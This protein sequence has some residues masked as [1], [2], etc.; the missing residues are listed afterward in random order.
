MCLAL[1]TVLTALAFHTFDPERF[2]IDTGLFEMIK[3]SET[4][5]LENDKKTIWK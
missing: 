1:L 3:E 5:V 4:F 2:W